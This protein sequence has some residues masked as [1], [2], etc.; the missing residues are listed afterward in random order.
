VKREGKGG[1]HRKGK[2][3]TVVEERLGTERINKPLSFIQRDIKKKKKSKGETRP[4]V[5]STREREP[6]DRKEFIPCDVGGR[7]NHLL[8]HYKTRGVHWLGGRGAEYKGGIG[9]KG[10]S[11]LKRPRYKKGTKTAC[12]GGG[13]RGGEKFEKA[14]KEHLEK[15][16][17][18]SLR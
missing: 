13:V 11:C 2:G 7:E 6:E 15:A 18:I 9:K 4:Y 1:K 8:G 17:R 14:Y 12:R 3:R 5:Y 16:Q 10:K